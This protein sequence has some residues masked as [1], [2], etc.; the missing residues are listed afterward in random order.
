MFFRFKIEVKYKNCSSIGIVAFTKWLTLWIWEFTQ[1]AYP[2]ISFLHVHP[3]IKSS[4]DAV[5]YHLDRANF[6]KNYP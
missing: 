5:I 2:W 6:R 4:V 1:Y 3:W